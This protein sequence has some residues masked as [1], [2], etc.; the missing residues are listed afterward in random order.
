VRG[1]VVLMEMESGT[2]WL[3]ALNLGARA[4][5]YIDKGQSGKA[6]F[7][8]K[9]ELTP[10]NFPRF[11]L[12]RDRATAFFGALA[13]LPPRKVRLTSAVR[14]ETVQLENLYCLIPG[15][16]SQRR[17]DLIMVE[18]FY[19]APAHVYGRSPGAEAALGIATLLDLAGHLEAH[20]P[21]RSFLLVATNAQAQALSG[22]REMVW[23]LAASS[24]QMRGS[25]RTLRK[26]RRHRPHP[27]RAVP[28]P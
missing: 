27:G 1:A 19:D 23:S 5:I 20:P 11:W 4:V 18:A 25:K 13:D 3:H 16:D 24:R 8:E 12:E 7:A 17:E 10:V 21:Q 22:M 28:A 14:W 15:S 26:R 9:L 2:N 6:A